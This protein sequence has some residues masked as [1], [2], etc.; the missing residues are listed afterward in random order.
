MA[1]TTA[2]FAADLGYMILDLPAVAYWYGTAI[3]CSVSD[4]QRQETLGMTGQIESVDLRVEFLAS[5][6]TAMTALTTDARIAIRRQGEAATSNYK[7]VQLIKPADGVGITAVCAA[8]RRNTF[9]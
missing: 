5:S 7:I 1:I 9:P 4:L 2:Y 3:N 6:F 8:D